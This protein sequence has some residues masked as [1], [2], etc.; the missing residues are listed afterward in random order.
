MVQQQSPESQVPGKIMDWLKD[1]LE[2]IPCV[3]ADEPWTSAIPLAA[4]RA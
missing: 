4:F 1:L 2:L 3:D